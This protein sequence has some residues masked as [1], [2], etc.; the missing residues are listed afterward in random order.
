YS[1]TRHTRSPNGKEIERRPA[2]KRDDHGET[3][4]LS[5]RGPCTVTHGTALEGL[6]DAVLPRLAETKNLKIDMIDVRELDT[7]GAWLFE[8]MSRIA[9]ASGHSATGVGAAGR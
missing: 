5:P 2:I 6:F 3:L 1:P 4:E 9:L 7:L 8:K